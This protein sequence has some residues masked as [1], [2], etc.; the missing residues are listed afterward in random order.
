MCDKIKKKWPPKTYFQHKLLELIAKEGKGGYAALARK[1][2]LSG[3]AIKRYIT[4]S[5]KPKQDSLNKICKAGG[6]DPSFFDEQKEESIEINEAPLD[7]AEFQ[8]RNGDNKSIE[9]DG[10]RYS[11]KELMK[12]AREVLTS[13]HPQANQLAANILWLFDQIRRAKQKELYKKNN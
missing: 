6:V 11:I 13:D 12:I 4:G 1:S 7:I 9:S 10:K 3:N 5:A 8:R 2:G